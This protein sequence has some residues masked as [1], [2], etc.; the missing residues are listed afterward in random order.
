MSGSPTTTPVAPPTL[1]QHTREV[2]G[3]VLGYSAER[4]AEL[5]QEGAIRCGEAPP[6]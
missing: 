6:S 2:L 1:G 3:K 5:K 4:I